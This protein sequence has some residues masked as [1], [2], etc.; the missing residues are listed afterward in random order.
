MEEEIIQDANT[1]KD[2]EEASR[3]NIFR[4]R[5]GKELYVNYR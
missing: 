5:E 3:A 2:L 1:Q 4:Y